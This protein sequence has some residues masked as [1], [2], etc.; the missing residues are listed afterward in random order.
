MPTTQDQLQLE[1]D[2]IEAG[3][4]RYL[5]AVENAESHGRGSEAS[6]GVKLIRTLV[7]PIAE[8]LRELIA[9]K[10]TPNKHKASRLAKYAA[11]LAKLPAELVAFNSLRILLD[12]VS[13]K[14]YVSLTTCL[15]KVGRE[16]ES[17]LRFS[18][19]KAHNE[20]YFNAVIANSQKKKSKDPK[21]LHKV[22]NNLQRKEGFTWDGWT[23]RDCAS[24]AD[25]VLSSILAV[26]DIFEVTNIIMAKKAQRSHTKTMAVIRLTAEAVEWITKHKEFRALLYPMYQPMIV[27]PA[28]WV[29]MK[30]GGY[31]TGDVRARY[32]FVRGVQGKVL[33]E[34]TNE[35]LAYAYEMV[36]KIQ[37]TP[38]Q[39]NKQVMDV[40]VEVWER[41]LGM[42]LPNS[43]PIS[44]PPSQFADRR[45]EDLNE[46]EL[47]LLSEWKTK[48]R[49]L[50]NKE[51]ERKALCYSASSAIRTAQKFSAYD[52][53]WFPMNCDHR[54]RVYS[55]VPVFN[56]QSD[57]LAKG[58]LK[59][60]E[61]KPLGTN[62][63]YWLMVHGANK[64][65]YDKVSYDARVDWVTEREKEI[66]AIADN[67]L[68][69][70]ELWAA[71]DKPFQYLA[72]CFEY[73][74]AV[75]SGN[76]E[77]YVS[78]LPCAL[79]GSC[80]GL[81]H[82]SAM[83]RDEV[84][85]KATNLVNAEVPADIYSEVA[86]VATNKLATS[87][88]TTQ[89][90]WLSFC[91]KY[92]KGILP[93]KLA[94]KPVMTLPYGST[95]F[96]CTDSI[97]EFVR[98]TDA[99]WFGEGN[100]FV[101][102][103]DLTPILWGSISE[104]VIAAREAMDWLQK[105]SRVITAAGEPIRWDTPNGFPVCQ[106]QFKTTDVLRLETTLGKRL[107]IVEDTDKLDPVKQESGISPNFVHSMD[108]NH[109][110]ATVKLAHERGIDSFACI[111]DDFGTHCCDI[112]IFHGCIRESFVAL[113]DGS[114]PIG[115]FYSRYAHLG[116]DLP[117]KMG[118]LNIAEV[119]TSQF[120]FG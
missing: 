15:V 79:D 12:M 75:K 82:F 90:E 74:S 111:H 92:G 37:A 45:K 53:I 36:S 70:M 44:I 65:G 108:A 113:Y 4:E 14:N 80:N 21:H 25:I 101:A 34:Y 95:Q 67:P 18:H 68:Q 86:R 99:D 120:F 115:D 28:P 1:K 5:K 54:G 61:G 81:Q 60:G 19:L 91:L 96:S 112:E 31:L 87:S 103:R 8:E 88:L 105:C 71:A 58:M 35:K 30:D 118:T 17:E 62:G 97:A 89:R 119:L 16:I 69:Y 52:K 49:D 110:L 22:L 73:A 50:H 6:Y 11:V 76:V 39:V 47:Q 63:F 32:R 7:V 42:V 83:L 59:F 24:I 106:A 57:D 66:L 46:L 55:I 41:D 20:S 117:P 77:T 78:S 29:G 27:P 84:G 56:P 48:V 2:M 13:N 72:F 94:K 93:R 116:I 40:A 104:V 3:I 23:N 98:D 64:Y 26:S 100:A 10:T 38:W 9:E 114:D 51:S 102:A 33:A 43:Q 107:R 85:G 109:M